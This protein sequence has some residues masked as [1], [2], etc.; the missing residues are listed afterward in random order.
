MPDFRFEDEAVRDG[1]A[2]I[3]GI[4]EAGRGPWAGPVVAAAVILDPA[5]IP[6]GVRDSKQVDEERRE[7]L[8]ADIDATAMIGVGMASVREIDRFNILNATLIAMRRAV[9]A[10]PIRP[11]LALVDGN[12]GPRL[13]CR[14]ETVVGGDANCLSIAAASIVAKVTRDRLMRELARAHPCYGWDRNK[15]YGTRHHREALDRHGL[16]P[17]HRRSFRPIHNMLY[18][19]SSE[20]SPLTN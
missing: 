9:R 19:T 5:H 13:F 4:D 2:V 14:T 16:T 20:D 3:A 12:R 10:L 1:K 6:D 18:R 17:H 15:G 7:S 8:F 11:G